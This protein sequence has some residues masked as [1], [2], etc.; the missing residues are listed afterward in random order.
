MTEND[1]Q[2]DHTIS[3]LIT[4]IQEQL[5]CILYSIFKNILDKIRKSTNVFILCDMIEKII[6]QMFV[7]LSDR[8]IINRCMLKIFFF[9]FHRKLFV[10]MI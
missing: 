1:K 8:L 3:L 6:K 9:F 10:K 2:N 4:Q 7:Y 5:V